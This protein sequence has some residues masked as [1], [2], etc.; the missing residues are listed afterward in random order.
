[1]HVLLLTGLIPPIRFFWHETRSYTSVY[2]YRVRFPASLVLT[3]VFPHPLRHENLNKLYMVFEDAR[4]VTL[5]LE[6]CSQGDVFKMLAEHKGHM[7]EEV[8]V[9][10]VSCCHVASPWLSI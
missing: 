7:D 4:R 3:S 2:V 8:V 9:V 6:Y 10:R 5:V 1:M